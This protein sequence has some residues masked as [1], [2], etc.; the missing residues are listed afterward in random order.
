LRD[1]PKP[2]KS[3]ATSCT[4][5]IAAV[6]LTSAAGRANKHLVVNGVGRHD[7]FTTSLANECVEARRSNPVG[8]DRTPAAYE[9][10]KSSDGKPAVQIDLI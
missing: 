6:I 2:L 9:Y 3:S 5:D 1:A 4:I 8:E 10:G 7:C